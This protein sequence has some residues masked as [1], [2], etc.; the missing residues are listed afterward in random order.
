MTKTKA[1]LNARV[2]RLMKITGEGQPGE[3]YEQQETDTAIDTAH[4]ELEIEGVAYWSVE[5]IPDA[6]F[7]QV[8]R[9]TAGIAAAVLAPHNEL[10][11][12][13]TM[14]VHAL[15][16]LY[17]LTAAPPTGEPMTPQYF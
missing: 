2:L 9:Y 17:K 8:A 5:T 6:L 4:G 7:E 12:F 16:Q 14:Q 1:D 11:K 15:R 13:M 3:A 10:D